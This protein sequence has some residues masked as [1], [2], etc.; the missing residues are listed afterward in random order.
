MIN[1]L[2]KTV[3]HTAIYSLGNIST[4]L[5]G[6]VLLPLYTSHLSTAE[7]GVLSIIEITSQL[8]IG[9]FTFNLPQA[10]LRWCATEK[11]S[12][13]DKSIVFS[14]L[15]S[16]LIIAS[17]V[18]GSL[19]PLHSNLS[20]IF[21]GNPKFSEYF[22]LLLIW[23]FIGIINRL[24]NSLLR[25]REK[26]LIFAGVMVSKFIVILLANIYFVA[27]VELGVTGIVWGQI[28]GE[29]YALLITSPFILK[30]ITPKLNISVIK[31]MVAYG[32]PMA[33]SSVSTLILSS[34]DRY[35][36]SYYLS[37]GSV[38][39]YALAQKIGGVINVFL[40][41]SFQQ[42]FFPIAFKMF[43]EE[44]PSRYYSKVL[45][46]FS[47]I[48]CISALGISLLSE[49]LIKF[50]TTRNYY[51]A[52]L[53]VPF[54][55][56]AFVIKGIGLVFTLGFHYA[57]KTS[58]YALIIVAG[59]L[60]TILLN[61]VLIPLLDVY[62]AA[63]AVVISHG[64]M[65]IATFKQ[66]QKLFFIKFEISKVIKMIIIAIFLYLMVFFIQPNN[67]YI[68]LL[69]KIVIFISY[70]FLLYYFNIF[71]EIEISTLRNSWKKWRNPLKWRDNFKKIKL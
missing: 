5:V 4:K 9:L 55:A 6:L 70:P 60:L 53:I 34:G 14:T 45:T 38:G 44:T 47:F 64:A 68:S 49:E 8:L 33:L 30:N 1:K 51:A 20:E 16:L 41:N 36:L 63:I 54:I 56:F 37:F 40:L 28:I 19:L 29:V 46:Y 71:E 35:I 21:F 17:L 24:P 3:K 22:L 13:R 58:V 67:S 59:M 10:M 12:V 66:A 69:V 61:I 25:L 26:S 15:I 62:G 27:V 39:I 32:F 57:K 42:G 65:S 23:A 31:E 43:N 18:I 7:Y 11:D 52:Y 50:L 2:K 48:L